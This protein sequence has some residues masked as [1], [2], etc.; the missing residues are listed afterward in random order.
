MRIELVDVDDI[1]LETCTTF[2]QSP[3]EAT[4]SEQRETAALRHWIS[5]V[6]GDEKGKP[7]ACSE[8]KEFR[9]KSGEDYCLNYCYNI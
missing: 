2:G 9:A 3:M 6:Q 4:Q 1:Q 7:K 8:D 5:L